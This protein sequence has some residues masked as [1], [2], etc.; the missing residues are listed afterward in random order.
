MVPFLT[1]SAK[2]FGE[3]LVALAYSDWLTR[4][5]AITIPMAPL[6]LMIHLCVAVYSFLI[7]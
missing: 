4:L 7:C 2:W 5:S 1:N 3:L 6:P